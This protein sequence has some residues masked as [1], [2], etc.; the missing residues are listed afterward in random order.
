MRTR[1][2]HMSFYAD[3]ISKIKKSEKRFQVVSTTY[4]KKVLLEREQIIFNHEGQG[5]DNLLLLVNMVRADAKKYIST[6]PSFIKKD[7]KVDFFNL[8][9]VVT[10]KKMITK[11][12]C[13]SAYWTYAVKIG[14]VS[15]KTDEYLLSVC[16]NLTAS[17]AKELRLKALG[18]LSTSKLY[19]DWENGKIIKEEIKREATRDIYLEIC[20]GIDQLM[21]DTAKNVD[22]CIY[23]YWDCI[24]VERERNEAVID[25][26]KSQGYDV[27]SEE[28]SVE[29]IRIGENGYILSKSDNKMYMTRR[30]DS[31]LIPKFDKSYDN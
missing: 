9:E 8:L 29:F 22:G 18:S 11:I 19:Q 4:T 3:K 12:D 15:K 5:D 17:Y 20:R 1:Y 13:K 27:T 26:I 24:F 2:I 14:I 30:E 23:Y 31:H 16:K 21:K 10:N 28:T 7:E 25:F 6:N